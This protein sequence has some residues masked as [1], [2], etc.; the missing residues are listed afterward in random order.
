ML[1]VELCKRITKSYGLQKTVK[2][3]QDRLITYA[4]KP[5]NILYIYIS[6]IIAVHFDIQPI[7]PTFGSIIKPVIQ[8]Q[9]L[10]SCTK[11]LYIAVHSNHNKPY[12]A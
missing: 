11:Y 2:Q 10:K 4:E 6:I 3:Q 8:S 12:W 5:F 7:A 9:T 1:T